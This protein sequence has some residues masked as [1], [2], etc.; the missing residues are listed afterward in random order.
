MVN[1][2]TF[3]LSFGAKFPKEQQKRRNIKS[4]KKSGLYTVGYVSILK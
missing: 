3:D 2:S 4:G 1:L